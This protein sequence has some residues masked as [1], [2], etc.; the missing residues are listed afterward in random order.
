MAT[1]YLTYTSV[2]TSVSGAAYEALINL[3]NGDHY[4]YVTRKLQNG[5]NTILDLQQ[6]DNKVGCLR[7]AGTEIGLAVIVVGAAVEWVFRALVHAIAQVASCCLPKKLDY[8]RTTSEALYT[9]TGTVLMAAYGLYGNLC[10]EMTADD[11][12]V[13]AE[14]AYAFVNKMLSKLPCCRQR[15][16]YSKL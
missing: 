4:E 5:T 15:D 3:R 12:Y 14:S 10:G 9:T 7:K 8:S 6:S 1:T 13:M 11:N 2:C 16:D